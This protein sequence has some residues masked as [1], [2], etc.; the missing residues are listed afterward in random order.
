[1][2][3]VFTGTE[4][5][6]ACPECRTM[7]NTLEVPCYCPEDDCGALVTFRTIKWTAREIR[8][9]S[10]EAKK[11]SRALRG[12]DEQSVATTSPKEG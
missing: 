8:R 1:M 5:R 9:A 3:K 2:A 12:G 4:F 6:I 11:L 7:W 10:G